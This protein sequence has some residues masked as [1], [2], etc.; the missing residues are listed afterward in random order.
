MSG[1]FRDLESWQKA[2]QL[3][4]DV[5]SAT[6]AFPRE[7]TYRLTI[8]LRRAAVSVVSNIAESK[9]RSTDKDTLHFLANAK[10]SLFELETQLELAKHLSYLSTARA[11]AL[12]AKTNEAGRLLNGLMRVFRS[13]STV[14]QTTPIQ[15]SAS[16]LAL[17]P[18]VRRP[19]PE[20]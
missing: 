9:G 2:F 14:Q 7:E 20:A 5:Y 18:E 1:T 10:G 4:L 16:R 13:S 15:S 11:D 17:V 6:R 12:I 3:A 8:Q 19:E